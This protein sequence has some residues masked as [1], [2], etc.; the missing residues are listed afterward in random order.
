MIKKS[1]SKYFQNNKFIIL[2]VGVLVFVG[3]ASLLFRSV[4]PDSSISITQADLNEKTEDK[5]IEALD[6][7]GN[8][9]TDKQAGFSI[10]CPTD[11]KIYTYRNEYNQ[12]IK[13]QE[14]IVFLCESQISSDQSHGY[15]LCPSG[16]VMVWANGDGWGGGCNPENKSTIT[17]NGQSQSYCLYSTGF[18]QLYSGDIYSKSNGNRFLIEGSFSKSFTKEDALKILGTFKVL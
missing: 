11:L 5:K 10:I 17:L 7:T 12:Y 18:G 2:L 8:I 1:S 9:L 14:K 16:G 4:K 3:V 6:C 13:K 15:Y